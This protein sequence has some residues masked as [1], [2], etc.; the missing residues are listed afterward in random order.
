MAR[1]KVYKNRNKLIERYADLAD[2]DD[3]VSN[4]YKDSVVFITGGTGFIGKVLI[5]KL[6]REFNIKRIYL[7]VRI[8]NNMTVDE[9]LEQFFQESVIKCGQQFEC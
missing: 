1:M 4:F 3:L 2:G 5:E 6:L 8:K 7:L 9:R